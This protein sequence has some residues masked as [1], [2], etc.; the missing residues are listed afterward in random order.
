MVFSK[1]VHELFS[2]IQSALLGE[3]EV[4]CW[5]DGSGSDALSATAE[6]TPIASVLG[7]SP[8]LILLPHPSTPHCCRG[9]VLQ[10][11]V[12]SSHV[13]Q[14]FSTTQHPRGLE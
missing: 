4:H 5:V 12:P 3:E 8:P 7:T 1:G 6:A 11:A 2:W 10:Y 13:P 14:R 9:T